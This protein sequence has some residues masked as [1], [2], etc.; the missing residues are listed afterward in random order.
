MSTKLFVQVK[1]LKT[2]LLCDLPPFL[3]LHNIIFLCN[4]CTYLIIFCVTF[5]LVLKFLNLF[6]FYI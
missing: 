4:F 5:M 6:Q 1:H 2:A 3:K